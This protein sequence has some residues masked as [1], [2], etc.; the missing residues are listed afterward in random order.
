MIKKYTGLLFVSLLLSAC[1]LVDRSNVVRYS[2]SSQ[3][4]TAQSLQDIKPGKTTHR[5]LLNHIGV[6]SDIAKQGPRR[7]IWRYHL[8]EIKHNQT[9]IAFLYKNNSRLKSRCELSLL[10]TDNVVT[11][12]W[13]G[14][15]AE[16]MAR[17]SKNFKLQLA[18]PNADMPM[19]ETFVYAEVD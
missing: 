7:E 11:A 8:N 15:S 18:H 10:L 13:S 3:P 14:N 9:H 16:I 4:V 1:T 5:W 2:T 17:V 12:L 6:A 19:C